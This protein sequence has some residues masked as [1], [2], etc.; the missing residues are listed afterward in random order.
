ML[1]GKVALGNYYFYSGSRSL[2][3]IVDVVRN[4]ISCSVT[5]IMFC[6]DR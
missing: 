2:C 4:Y 5:S 1:L 3:F 6:V